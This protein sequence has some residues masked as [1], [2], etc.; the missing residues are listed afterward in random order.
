[1]LERVIYAE[2][3]FNCIERIAHL[4]CTYTESVYKGVL[5]VAPDLEMESVSRQDLS[6]VTDFLKRTRDWLSRSAQ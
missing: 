6:V 2:W 3:S 5:A 1:M 4:L